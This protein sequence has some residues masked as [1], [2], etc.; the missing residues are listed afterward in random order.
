MHIKPFV[1]REHSWV[2]AYL[3]GWFKADSELSKLKV[4]AHVWKS[5]VERLYA[6]GNTCSVHAPFN[7]C[8]NSNHYA[9]VSFLAMRLHG[10]LLEVLILVIKQ[11]NN[12]LLIFFTNLLWSLA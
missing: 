5:L 10:Y 4:E 3:L 2:I 11:L 6:A 1:K 8:R 7:T 9:K 12:K